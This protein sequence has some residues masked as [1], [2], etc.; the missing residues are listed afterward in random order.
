MSASAQYIQPQSGEAYRQFV[1][2]AH[3]ALLRSMPDPNQRNQAVWKSWYSV[4]GDPASDRAR[5]IFP[6]SEYRTVPNVCYF[7]EHSTKSRATG[8][9]VVYDFHKLA[10]IVDEHAERM[11]TDNYTAMTDGHTVDRP[12]VLP[13]NYS[14]PPQPEV[15]GYAGPYRLGMTGRDNP[16]FAVFADEHHMRSAVPKLDKKKRRSVEVNRF[17]DG[18]R[19]F[20]DPVAILGSE[21]PRLALPIARYAED[22][23]IK[24]RYEAPVSVSGSNTYL[25]APIKERHSA[26]SQD[27]DMN[28]ATGD[29]QSLIRNILAAF[30]QTNEMQYLRS[31]M[32]AGQGGAQPGGMPGGD[33]MGGGD[34]SQNPVSQPPAS[35]QSDPGQSLP[36]GGG[37]PGMGGGNG[38]PDMSKNR[39]HVTDDVDTE[40]VERFSAMQDEHAE[41]SERYAMLEEAN[42]A[43]MKEMARMKAAV[44]QLEQR[45]VDAERTERIKD[46]YSQYPHF[47]DVG[48]E[49]EVCLYSHGSDMGAE[50]FDKHLVKLEKYAKQ[51]SP[52]TR[53]LPG[54]DAGMSEVER[55]SADFADRVV[56]RYTLEANRG[57]VLSYEEVEALVREGK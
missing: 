23:A 41:L 10:D 50:A 52:T 2:R 6:E 32:T 13:A 53:M 29:Q 8:E 4:H 40:L 47:I 49:L 55:N 30:M 28:P 24:E 3:R 56:E 51:S 15:V 5:E 11:D 43:N 22:G 9:P 19:P 1:M 26:E 48:D 42:K 21:A 57:R 25:P 12:A 27:V 38:A 33:P 54:A 7:M 36:A 35:P 16:K 45:T 14:P 17:K 46:L 37:D 39:Y 20:F 31:L 34:P 44:V 18:R